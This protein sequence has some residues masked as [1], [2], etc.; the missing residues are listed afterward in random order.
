MRVEWNGKKLTN[1]RALF[2]CWK[3]WEWMAETEELAWNKNKWPKWY[4]NGGKVTFCTNHCPCCEYAGEFEDTDGLYEINC[5]KCPLLHLWS[6]KK[7]SYA[8]EKDNSSPYYRCKEAKT[9]KTHKK[10]AKIISD[11]A[12]KKYEEMK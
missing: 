10:Y 7:I 1:K 6:K 12:K 11:Y 9:Y 4:G 3:L 5:N 2:L 8:C